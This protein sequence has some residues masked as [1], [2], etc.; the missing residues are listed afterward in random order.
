MFQVMGDLYLLKH[1]SNNQWTG[2][3]VLVCRDLL[4]HTQESQFLPLDCLW[5]LPK[6]F[7]SPDRRSSLSLQSNVI[8]F[9]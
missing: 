5:P 3:T 9:S 1:T 6:H 2:D 4:V 7:A 8:F